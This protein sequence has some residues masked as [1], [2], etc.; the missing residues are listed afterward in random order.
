M[1]YIVHAMDYEGDV[2]STTVA[3]RKLAL[4]LAIKWG[5]QGRSG[6]TISGD[7]R[8]YTAKELARAI[9]EKE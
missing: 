6:V 1:A 9:I 3:D 4:A 7:G 2:I 8:K 5:S